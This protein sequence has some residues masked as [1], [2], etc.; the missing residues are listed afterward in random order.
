MGW[1][2][3]SAFQWLAR[4]DQYANAWLVARGVRAG[5]AQVM[6]WSI[7]L[8]LLTVLLYVT[9]WLALLVT[10]VVIAAWVVKTINS[11]EPI[12]WAIGEQADYRKSVF[13]DPLYYN[14]DPDPRFEDTR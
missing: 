5:A 13:Y 7:K 14:D 3:R 8:A 4:V 1:M 2:A 11:D 12:E 6:R 10:F 9:V